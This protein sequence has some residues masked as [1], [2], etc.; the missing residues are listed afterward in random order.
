VIIPMILGAVDI[1]DKERSMWSV[2]DGLDAERAGAM[3]KSDAWWNIG[4]GEHG[5]PTTFFNPARWREDLERR[6]A[7]PCLTRTVG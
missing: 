7:E 3:L 6:K 1:P 4:S 5:A 2:L